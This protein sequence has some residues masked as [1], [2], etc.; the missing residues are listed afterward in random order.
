MKPGLDDAKAIDEVA[1]TEGAEKD[2]PFADYL[3]FVSDQPSCRSPTV[4]HSGGT[5]GEGHSVEW[6]LQDLNL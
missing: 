4:P 1:V 3:D 2:S 5:S 6:A